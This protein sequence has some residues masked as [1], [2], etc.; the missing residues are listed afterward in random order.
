VLSEQPTNTVNTV[1]F[2]RGTETHIRILDALRTGLLLSHVMTPARGVYK[3]RSKDGDVAISAIAQAYYTLFGHGRVEVL[4]DGRCQ[5][6]T[7]IQPQHGYRVDLVTCRLTPAANS[8]FEVLRAILNLESDAWVLPEDQEST[9]LLALAAGAIKQHSCP[10]DSTTWTA[11]LA[12]INA[13]GVAGSLH[14]RSVSRKLDI[15][16]STLVLRPSL[17][18][19]MVCLYTSIPD[20]L[21]AL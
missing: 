5:A 2:R 8:R 21:P 1:H 18:L 11:L 6:D 7:V 10:A 12:W 16:F 17:C 14:G 20:K 15:C 9:N 19:V 13:F 3:H 4:S